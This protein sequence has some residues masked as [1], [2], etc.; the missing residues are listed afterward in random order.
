VSGDRLPGIAAD[1]LGANVTEAERI[2]LTILLHKHAPAER[3]SAMEI[4][5]ILEFIEGRGYGIS[6]PQPPKEDL[7]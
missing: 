4:R 3:L 6:I 1:P 5:T 2:T 7:K